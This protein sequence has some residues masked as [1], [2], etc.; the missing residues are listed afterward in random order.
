M[1]DKKYKK[2]QPHLTE[3]KLLTDG[4]ATPLSIHN[5]TWADQIPLS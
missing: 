2:E 3:G 5:P 4:A 1:S